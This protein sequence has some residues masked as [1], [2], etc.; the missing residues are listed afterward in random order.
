MLLLNNYRCLFLSAGLPQLQRRDEGR[1]Q[2]VEERVADVEV[3]GRRE[4][5]VIIVRIL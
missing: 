1:V 4:D 3:I 5:L 2:P